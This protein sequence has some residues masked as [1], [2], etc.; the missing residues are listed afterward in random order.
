MNERHH[1]GYPKKQ[2]CKVICCLGECI[3]TQRVQHVLFQ[4]IR[5]SLEMC[6]HEYSYLFICIALSKYLSAMGKTFQA[7]LESNSF[8]YNES[9]MF[10]YVSIFFT[11]KNVTICVRCIFS[12]ANNIA[13]IEYMRFTFFLRNKKRHIFFLPI[14]F[15]LSNIFTSIYK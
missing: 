4:R 9:T 14:N 15:S 2:N 5:G 12:L 8:R 3:H 10:P 13:S 7:R 6:I 1:T 11:Y